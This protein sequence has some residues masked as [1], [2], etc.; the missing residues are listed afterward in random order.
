MHYASRRKRVA[1]LVSRYDHC[2]A[3]LLWRWRRGELYADIPLIVSNHPDLASEA[4]RFGV[5]FEHVPV[6]R[7]AKAEAERALLGLLGGHLRPDRAG[8]LHADPQPDLPR[9]GADAD[10]QHPPLVPA[11]RSPAPTRT[12]GRTSAA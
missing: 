11:A 10:H 5:H 2:L 1:I 7:D 3:E 12:R 8:A 9:G 6:E 4:E